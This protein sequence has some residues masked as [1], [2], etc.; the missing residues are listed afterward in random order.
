MRSYALISLVALA[1]LLTGCATPGA[2][3]PPSLNVPN[4]VTDLKGARKGEV[5]NLTWTAPQET[6]D[7]A[8]VHGKHGSGKMVVR[9]A[10]GDQPSPSVVD[11]LPLPSAHKSGPPQAQSFKDSV[12]GLGSDRSSFA[13]YTV[14][15]LNGS[16]KSAGPSNQVTVPLVPVM[17]APQGVQ[18]QVTAQGVSIAWKQT[19]PPKNPTLLNARYVYR[20]MRRADSNQPAVMISQA[21]A[22]NEAMLVVDT[23]IE[24]EKTYQYWITPAT[25]WEDPAGHGANARGEVPGEDSQ[26]IAVTTKDIFPPAAPSGLQAAFSGNFQRLF[27]D[28]AWTPNNESD[29]AG[30]NVYRR[31]ADEQQFKKLNSDLVKP[32]AFRDTAVQ[33]GVKYFYEVTAVDLRN[34]ESPRSVEASETVPRE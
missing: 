27:I 33:P 20:I 15:T 7:G 11:E 30:Y 13:V 14:E 2:P 32:P 34:N 23:G 8:L 25:L 22:N 16:A 24:W 12:S 26:I 3:Q 1:A 19:G 4:A 6:T 21:D 10:T 5:V 17:Q 28:L 18:A 29:L 31:A 9:R